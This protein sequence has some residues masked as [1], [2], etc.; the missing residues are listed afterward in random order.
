MRALPVASSW[1]SSVSAPRPHPFAP[2]I[3]VKEAALGSVFMWCGVCGVLAKRIP[4]EIVARSTAHIIAHSR[5]GA[6]LQ[7]LF[8][9]AKRN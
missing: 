8:Q 5:H 3:L 9:D 4:G 6:P 1:A 2:G 7:V